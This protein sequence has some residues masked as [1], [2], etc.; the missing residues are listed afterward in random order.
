MTDEELIQVARL[1]GL[2]VTDDKPYLIARDVLSTSFVSVREER[3]IWFFTPTPACS[4]EDISKLPEG[5][6]Y[7]DW[8]EALTW[9]I[10][11]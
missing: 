7:E 2:R 6:F 4:T 5:P 1:K 11:N 9:A 8:R 10:N 3:Y